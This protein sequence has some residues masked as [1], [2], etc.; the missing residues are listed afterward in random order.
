L[1]ISTRPE[2]LVHGNIPKALH[3]VA[4]REIMPSKW[5]EKERK[6]SY[7]ANDYHCW[8][9]GN[10]KLSSPRKVLEAHEAYDIDYKNGTVELKE[11]VALCRNCHMFIHSGRMLSM[12]LNGELSRERTLRILNLGFSRLKANGLK[13]FAGTVIVY[14]IVRYG[15]TEEDATEVARSRF[16]YSKDDMN[17]DAIPWNSWKLVFNDKEYYSLFKDKP[18]WKMFYEE[19]SRKR[20]EAMDRKSQ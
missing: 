1:T 19:V 6:A 7:A 13:P 5:W 3:G 15:L 9:C 10:H 18:E 2:L 11:I 4:P 12:F 8:C 20:R 16:G 14:L 17:E